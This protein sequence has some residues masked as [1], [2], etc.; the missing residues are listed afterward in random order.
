[1]GSVRGSQVND[2]VF[3]KRLIVSPRFQNQGIGTMPM[4]SFEDFFQDNKR[5]E[6]F[7]GHKSIRNLHLYLKLGYREF[8]QIPIHEI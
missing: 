3:I 8:K 7:T 5:Y 1:M 4:R 2:T 6:L